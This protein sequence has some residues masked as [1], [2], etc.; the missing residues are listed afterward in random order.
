MHKSSSPPLCLFWSCSMNA[1]ILTMHASRLQKLNPLPPYLNLS[2]TFPLVHHNPKHSTF[3]SRL[4]PTHNLVPRPTTPC[5]RIKF[6]CTRSF[7][8]AYLQHLQ[9]RPST[10]LWLQGN[11]VGSTTHFQH[12]FRLWL[13]Y[14]AFL[15][16]A[17]SEPGTQRLVWAI[18]EHQATIW[19]LCTQPGFTA[20][21][22]FATCLLNP[23]TSSWRYVLGNV[24]VLVCQGG[25]ND[26]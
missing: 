11:F 14:L 24:Y 6:T 3:T 18:M 10:A 20:F 16:T 13:Q 26:C 19:S 25:V 15:S 21:S 9:M 4:R 7:L 5:I 22:V 8:S 17:A 12:S 1:S 23:A 2:R